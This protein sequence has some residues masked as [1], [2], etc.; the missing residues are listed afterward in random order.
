MVKVQNVL[1]QP[2]KLPVMVKKR[3]Q[4]GSVDQNH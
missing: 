1:S 2:E 4:N 3:T